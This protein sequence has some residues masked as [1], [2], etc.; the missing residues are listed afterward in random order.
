MIVNAVLMGY[1]IEALIV[2]FDYLSD[3]MFIW[4]EH[5]GGGRAKVT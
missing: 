4:I 5:F 2:I 3:G 1:P